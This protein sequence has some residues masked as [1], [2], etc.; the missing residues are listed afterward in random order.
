[1]KNYC[2]IVL[3]FGCI[4]LTMSSCSNNPVKVGNQARFTVIT[5]GCI[6]MEFSESGRFIDEPTLFA[7][8]RNTKYNDFKVF[9]TDSNY[10]IETSAIKIIYRPD[11]NNFSAQNLK[12]VV[13]QDSLSIMWVPGTK[14]IANLGG[15][16]RTVDG[17]SQK[18][19][20]G[21]GL[22]SRD[23]WYL[24]DDS[25]RP[26]LKDN[27]IESR[28]ENSGTD[29]YFFGY[30]KNFKLALK[31][32]TAIG[33]QIPLPRKYVLGSWYSRYWPYSD[34]D[35]M[36][37]VEEYREHD[38]PLDVIVLDMDWHKDGWT[39]WSWNRKLL[40]EPAKLLKWF[41]DQSLYVT[42]NL[43]PA[44]GVKPYEDHY[45]EFLNEL[46]VDM[47][48]GPDSLST[49]PFDAS[50][51][52]YMNALFNTILKPLTDDGVDFWWLDWQQYEFTRSIQELK[53]LEWLNHLLYKYTGKDNLRGQSFSRWGG[54]GNHRYPINFS[55]DAVAVWPMLAFEV[56][57]TSTAGNVGCFFWSHDIGGH[58]GNFDQE[59]NTRWVQFG[60]ASAALRLHSTRDANMDKRPWRYETIYLN[61]MKNA[62]HLRTKLFPYIYSS[63]WESVKESIPLTCPMYIEYPNIEIAYHCPQ[64]YFFGSSVLVA[65][66]V[67][68]GSG[69]QKLAFQ[70]I[71]FPEGTWYNLFT[72]EKYN[73][74]NQYTTVWADINEFPIFVKGGVP[75]PLQ[76]FRQR[77]AMNT[78]DTLVVRVYPGENGQSGSFTLYED[79]GI[80]K[81]Y[82]DGKYALTN[83]VFSR[84][85]D[86]MNLSIE[87]TKGKYKGQVQERAYII[88]FPC[89]EKANTA[90]VDMNEAN[91]EYSVEKETNSIKIPA[92]K[93]DVPVKI[94]LVTSEI[95]NKLI[96][97]KHQNRRKAGLLQK[98]LMNK[99][100]EEIISICSKNCGIKDFLNI[101][102]FLTGV[103][104]SIDDDN[105]IIVKN[106][107][108]KNNL[109]VRIYDANG[110]EMNEV[111]KMV[112]SSQ[113]PGM[114]AAGIKMKPLGYGLKTTRFF[115]LHAMINNKDIAFK[116]KTKEILPA[117]SEWMVL[118]PFDFDPLKNIADFQYL[119][120]RE[121][122]IKNNETFKGKDDKTVKWQNT[123]S[124]ND[125]A[126]D[127]FEIFKTLNS[128]GYAATYIVSES[129]QDVV[130]SVN[131]DDGNELF[132][133]GKKIFSNNV[134][135]AF[136]G[137]V[138]IAKGRLHKGLN[139]FLVKISQA[140][141]GWEFSVKIDAEKKVKL[142]TILTAEK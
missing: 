36:Q 55:G 104:I 94:T 128:I 93:I 9:K 44:D 4:T 45:K 124:R 39:G 99:P 112:V 62:F 75:L 117:V 107:Y 137:H 7:Y 114:E 29:W 130:F 37:I 18:I 19:D 126:V 83:M 77:M 50:S 16:L 119:P 133:N 110:D 82:I 122:T 24:L 80:S 41:H 87:G 32:L 113:S 65:P 47:K 142:K 11:G 131:S 69:E 141:G 140:G 20:L 68:P 111:A 21:E 132:V 102:S 127:L 13:K 34:S 134:L 1:M 106:E 56:P 118:G 59:T 22:L 109:S 52:K 89:T 3:L 73:S 27:W 38:F 115:E 6:R 15:T 48:K 79:D 28:P 125:G 54:W 129:D 67:V 66:I 101:F 72:G 42:L 25:K 49:L 12:I 105:L 81:N 63:A 123:T 100:D 43:H 91:V 61:S 74:G 46:K 53:N 92:R 70:N 23:G 33:G 116:A 78:L 86:S 40:P 2:T 14:N 30:G 97:L 88:E 10:I 60:A 57:F 95:D 64:Q 103:S 5:P 85:G 96:A 17:I 71:W 90:I 26:L 121:L 84:M 120:E 76:P 108:R 98:G 51:K 135:R 35:Y 136:N 8:D 31:S 138:D 58:Y 139:L